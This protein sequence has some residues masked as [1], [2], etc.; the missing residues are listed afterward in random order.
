MLLYQHCHLCFSATPALS[1]TQTGTMITVSP[2][3][4][5]PQT[6]SF[7]KGRPRAGNLL[8]SFA[9]LCAGLLVNK[10]LLVFWH[11]GMLLYSEPTYYYYQQCLHIPATVSFWGS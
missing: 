7:G 11:M 3:L 9:I 1:V 5:F 2:A 6:N 4:V 8:L 10:V